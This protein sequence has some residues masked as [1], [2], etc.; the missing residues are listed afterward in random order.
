MYMECAI[1]CD[2]LVSDYLARDFNTHMMMMDLG[3]LLF[4]KL[5]SRG[6]NLVGRLVLQNLIRL[7]EHYTLCYVEIS[8]LYDFF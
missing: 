2:R 8:F 4:V 1:T 7:V 5:V 3:G 6:D